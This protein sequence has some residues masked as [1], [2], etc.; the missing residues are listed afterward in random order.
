MV[1]VSSINQLVRYADDT[2]L[3]IPASN[4]DTRAS[5]LDHV[6]QWAHWAA[7]NN[8]P[9]K[10]RQM[11]TEM[12]FVDSRRRRSV[13]P[14]PL[15]TGVKRVTTMTTLDVTVTNTLSVRLSG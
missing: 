15:L 8:L 14:T 5:E 2:Y 1:V 6:E 3:V 11:Y 7:F 10:P 12:I 9:V 4:V 13:E